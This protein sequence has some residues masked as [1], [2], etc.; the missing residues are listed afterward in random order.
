LLKLETDRR[1]NLR[2]VFPH[3][4]EALGAP[5]RRSGKKIQCPDKQRQLAKKRQWCLRRES[6]PHPS[7]NGIRPARKA[8]FPK[9]KRA[10]NAPFGIRCQLEI[11]GGEIIFSSVL[12]GRG[13]AGCF[14]F[15]SFGK[16]PEESPN[17]TGRDAA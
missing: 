12:A 4:N 1:V 17:T 14:R 2:S 5:Q 8:A 6:S 3:E 11:S 7:E 13:I 9:L 10:T 15:V 16:R